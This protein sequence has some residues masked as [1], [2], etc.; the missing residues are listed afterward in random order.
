MLTTMSS[1]CPSASHREVAKTTAPTSGLMPGSRDLVDP[2]RRRS[3]SFGTIT[4]RIEPRE[5]EERN[6]RGRHFL[7]GIRLYRTTNVLTTTIFLPRL[8]YTRVNLRTIVNQS[9][10]FL[11][12]TDVFRSTTVGLRRANMPS[13]HYWVSPRTR[14]HRPV[15]RLGITK[16]L[17]MPSRYMPPGYMQPYS[18]C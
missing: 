2:P 7:V 14:H 4:N 16:D 17:Q 18:P 5:M 15:S 13:Y 11:F 12:A 9:L 8:S 10:T 1:A 6:K 3:F